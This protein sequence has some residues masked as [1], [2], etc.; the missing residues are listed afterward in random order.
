MFKITNILNPLTGGSTTEEYEWVAGKTL[1]EYMDY[2]GE[3]VVS[4]G[5]EIVPLQLGEILPTK[6][7][8]YRVMPIPE[9]G[10]RKT[11]GVITGL[12]ATAGGFVGKFGPPGISQWGWGVAFAFGNVSAY[13]LKD[14][15]ETQS[16]SESYAW[17]HRS[18]PRASHGLAMPIIY[19]KARVRPVMKNRYI[20]VKG[21]VQR[22]Y[23]LYGLAAHKVD[24][25]EDIEV[26][27]DTPPRIYNT[28]DVVSTIPGT[29]TFVPGTSYRCK[30]THDQNDLVPFY[31]NTEYW[32]IWHGTAAFHNQVTINGRAIEEYH[33]D[34][35]WETRPGL[36]EQAVI[37]GFDVTYS[38]FVQNQVLYIN[39]MEINLKVA[40]IT[41]AGVSNLLIWSEHTGSL[42]G[43]EYRISNGRSILS[44]GNFYFLYFD[45]DFPTEY[46]VAKN[47]FPGD[48]YWVAKV[49]LTGDPNSS[50]YGKVEYPVKTPADGDWTRPVI[51]LT[52]LHNIELVLDFPFGLYGQPAGDI[53]SADA[54]IFAQYREVGSSTW[55]Y[56]NSTFSKPDYTDEGVIHIT[57]DKPEPFS[58]SLEAVPRTEA[59]D[60]DESYELQITASSPVT[61][62]LINIATITYG[63][64]DVD[65]GLSPGFTYP[66]EPLLGIKALASGQISGD[67]DV[68]VDVERSKVWVF[69][70]RSSMWVEGDAS[71]H[72]WAVYDILAQGHPDHPAYPAAGNADAEAVYGCGIDKGRLDYESFREWAEYTGG[73]EEGELDYELNIVFDAFVT[74]WDAILRICR[75]G[76]GMVYP[77]GT[78]IYAFADKAAD[79]TQV[80]TM[81]NIHLNT[82]VQQY[83]KESQ[84]V[85][86]VEVNYYDRERNYQKTTIAIRTADWDTSTGL[87]IPATITLYGTTGFDQAWSIGRFMLIGNELL[88][89][90]ITFGVDVDALAAR[91]GDVV[92]VQHDLLTSGQGGRIVNVVHNLLLN[93]SFESAL[94]PNWIEWSAPNVVY[95]QSTD[96]AKY[97]THSLH[98]RSTDDNG[99]GQQTFTVEPSTEYTLSCWIY[100]LN[101]LVGTATIRAMT[102]SGV[103]PFSKAF[104]DTG[105]L[106]QWQR[107]SVT[108]TTASDQTTAIVWLGGIGEAYFDGVMLNV[109]A[110]AEDFIGHTKL[111]MD[112]TLA[113][114]SGES[115]R[116]TI[117]HNDGSI[118]TRTGITS[119]N[120][121]GDIITFGETW[122]AWDKVPEQYEPYAIGIIGVDIKKYRITE[123]SRTNELMRMLTLVQY[124]EDIY[125]SYTPT[126]TLPSFEPDEVSLGKIAVGEE[127]IEDVASPLNL[128]SNL[129]L[130]EI[131]SKNRVTGEYESSVVVAWDP[132]LGDPHGTW[133]VWFRDVDASDVDWQ[134]AWE[135]LEASY[136]RG[137]K[138]E[139][140]GKVYISLADDNT[141]KPISL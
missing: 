93:G 33:D 138:V 48:K 42:L 39:F 129:Q 12:V 132:V 103:A 130:R 22:L 112:R 139:R 57:R 91:A 23:A 29:D 119:G 54:L 98:T 99:G 87:S 69:N 101:V 140:D 19:G 73:D 58:I 32:E 78:K 40:N 68:Q 81:G 75:E 105:L 110:T 46:I 136:D 90:V 100:M 50:D 104:A 126:S 9:G 123:I 5:G 94:L 74:A 80:F 2:D 56:F 21:D 102:R 137:N 30:K 115:Y 27:S 59:L 127:A 51:S 79:V 47:F 37:V 121:V 84:K 96:Q 18:S 49:D 107:V 17:Q 16:M 82:F 8:E 109:G 128:A 24:V 83:V 86:M 52:A 92:E 106:N 1:A 6:V 11:W 67:M 124:D 13:L 77:V 64:E 85:N 28:G 76:R 3:C 89:N 15:K 134:G 108:F 53:I 36:L 141:S 97:D 7:D 45:L 66:G 31:T 41:F 10:D 55:L 117:Y 35:E 65:A 26:W 116:L 133:E 61:V 14:D 62:R 122:S 4:C 63:T 131:I 60:Y 72:A 111:T 113:D 95:G 43:Q 25:D 20:T 125:G 118:E 114:V 38:N 71:V 135:A 44:D 88:N 70:T 34:V 120:I